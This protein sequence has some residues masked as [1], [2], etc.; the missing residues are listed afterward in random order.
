MQRSRKT[1]TQSNMWIQYSSTSAQACSSMAVA[2]SSEDSTL[3]IEEL[4]SM[5]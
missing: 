4:V 3:A 1:Q 5:N 2:C